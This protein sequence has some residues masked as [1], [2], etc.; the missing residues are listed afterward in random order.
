MTLLPTKIFSDVITLDEL[1]ELEI[2]IKSFN[3]VRKYSHDKGK[4]IN[5]HIASFHKFPYYKPESAKI[6]QIVEPI[7]LK[8][9]G[10]IPLI[11]NCHIL[12]AHLPYLLHTDLITINRVPGTTPEYS[13]LLPLQ[14]TECKTILFNEYSLTDIEFE[15]YVQA[16]KGKPEFKLDKNFCDK[17]LSHLHPSDLKY[18][19]L[20]TVFDWVAGSMI[21]F[22]PRYFHCSSNFLKQGYDNKQAV[23]LWSYT[24]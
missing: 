7:F 17:Y 9:L 6:R 12:D 20:Q 16:F 18:L 1:K 3:D 19:S 14:T 24:E 4:Y 11:D 10:K 23:L 2:L 21:M 13:M 8:T 5:Q 22:D 15:P